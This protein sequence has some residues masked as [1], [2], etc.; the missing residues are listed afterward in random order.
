[1]T[2]PN[3]RQ[4]EVEDWMKVLDRIP[5]V[6]A[7]KRDLTALRKLLYDRRA[8]RI[9]AIGAEGSGRTALVHALLNAVIFGEGGAPPPVAGSWVRIDADG[10]RVD[11]LELPIERDLDDLLELAKRAFEESPP[12]LV[13]ALIEAGTEED[14]TGRVHDAL[15]AILQHLATEREK[16]PPVL[17]LVTKVDLLPPK[18]AAAPY[19]PEKVTTIDAAV[20]AVKKRLGDL[21]ANE[22]LYL[23]VSARPLKEEGPPRWNV[24][25]VAET[26]IEKL[27]EAA[28]ME[29]VRAFEV[30]KDARRKVARALVNSCTAVALT[31]G[32]APIPFADAFVLLPLQAAM[33]TG[34][35]YL[36][37][38][39]WD[40]RAA[41]EW[42]ASV[43]VAGG[44]GMGLRWGAQQ[45]IKFLPG[46]GYIVGAG[47]AGAGTLA[48]GRSAIAYFVDGPGA[49]KKRP[50][51]RATN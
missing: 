45:L 41:A 20:T 17:V 51:L 40:K 1:M 37:G 50:E 36:S 18:E 2:E 32:L 39:A 33:V 46:A 12:D 35:A 22:E 49:I 27:P 34:V 7:M 24:D 43:G 38:R 11:W 48:I 10:R 47:V 44:A 5:V 9:A 23:A 42:I 3:R 21:V 31:V 13:L 4:S 19:P 15:A 30:G 8:P 16:K 28:Q 26:V 14:S 6:S 25:R 29:A